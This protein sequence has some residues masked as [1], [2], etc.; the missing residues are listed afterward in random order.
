V[1]KRQEF[2]VSI[3]G[4][5]LDPAMVQRINKAVQKAVLGELAGLDRHGDFA[6]RIGNGST[7]GIALIALTAEQLQRAGLQELG[8]PEG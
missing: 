8:G 5:E 1:A 3:D 4:A 6:A 2:R 7:N